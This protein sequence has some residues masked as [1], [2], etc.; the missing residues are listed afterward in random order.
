MNF[1][2]RSGIDSQ[3]PSELNDRVNELGRQDIKNL[4]SF[5][6]MRSGLEAMGSI[7]S[8]KQHVDLL[9]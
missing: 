5:K 6:S 3:E 1:N 7:K 2:P 9:I 8:N 4:D